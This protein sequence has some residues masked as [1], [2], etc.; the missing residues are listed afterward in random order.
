LAAALSVVLA[1][2]ATQ[3]VA[4]TDIFYI[5]GHMMANSA[6]QLLDQCGDDLTRE[7]VMWQVAHTD[8]RVPMLLPEM[9][10]STSPTELLP[11]QDSTAG[12][13]GRSIVRAVWRTDHR[14]PQ[15]GIPSPE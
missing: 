4:R 10:I 13:V 2:T 11:R 15:S 5:I 3:A 12:T 1:M 14:Y 9:R 8:F 6:V 7:N